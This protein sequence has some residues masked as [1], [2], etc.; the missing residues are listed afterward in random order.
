MDN[1]KLWGR[2]DMTMIR[3]CCVLQTGEQSA[4]EIGE[5]WK[6]FDEMSFAQSTSASPSLKLDCS[7]SDSECSYKPYP[8]VP[9]STVSSSSLSKSTHSASPSESPVYAPKQKCPKINICVRSL[10]KEA[11]NKDLKHNQSQ[12]CNQV[13]Y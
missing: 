9:S 10:N 11:L 6:L 8:A 2:V 13:R 4:S 5:F 3:R 1:L 12:Q 7:K